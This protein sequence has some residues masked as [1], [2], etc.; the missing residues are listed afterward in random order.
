MVPRTIA[1][2]TF[3]F[4]ERSIVGTCGLHHEHNLLLAA[5]TTVITNMTLYPIGKGWSVGVT[6]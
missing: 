4:H 3:T 2:I 5:C 6:K 1:R